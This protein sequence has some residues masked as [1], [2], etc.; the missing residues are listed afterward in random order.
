MVQRFTAR[1][2]LA[3]DVLAEVVP[4]L[5]WH[6]HA[7]REIRRVKRYSP[8]ALE[9]VSGVLAR[10]DRED[11]VELFE[12]QTLRFRN[13]SVDRRQYEQGSLGLEV[14]VPKRRTK[15][16][17]MAF[18]GQQQQNQNQFRS[19]G[20]SL[21]S[22][23]AYQPKA[24]CGL[25]AVSRRGKVRAT[26][27]SSRESGVSGGDCS[28]PVGTQ[29]LLK[30]QVTAVAYDMP[31]SRTYSG[32]AEEGRGGRCQRMAPLLSKKGGRKKGRR[33][34]RGVRERDRSCQGVRKRGQA[35]PISPLL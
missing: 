22:Q 9:V 14:D 3:Q 20:E 21:Y 10:G 34:L 16:V 30:S 28:K 15:T 31:T 27:K 35:T 13:C 1:Q 32:K 2:L 6:Q 11:L 19:C 24:P 33:T 29:N 8:D 23:A 5:N 18:P 12:R 25:K 7:W 4:A 17:P 26:M